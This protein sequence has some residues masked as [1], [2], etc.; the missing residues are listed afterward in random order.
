M[1]KKV[2]LASL[3]LLVSACSGSSGNSATSTKPQK[4]NVTSPKNIQSQ[5]NTN[6]QPK[7]EVKTQPQN[8]PKTQPK[9]E[10]KNQP[11]N[12]P[13]TQPKN[14]QSEI[15]WDALEKAKK[16][17]GVSDNNYGLRTPTTEQKDGK[18][19]QSSIYNQP[20]SLVIVTKTQT[21]S[22]HF[23][24]SVEVKGLKTE[25]LPSE[26]KATYVGEAFD[27]FGKNPQLSGKLS[28]D[29]DFAKQEGSGKV[30][31]D[32]GRSIDLEQG[33]IT[34][35]QISSTAKIENSETGTYNFS[36][37]GP[38]AEEIAGKIEM[39]PTSQEKGYSLGVA[40]TRYDIE[41]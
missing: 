34:Q 29:V 12:N 4:E 6:T 37:F 22:T 28:Y 7:N 39:K 23:S 15:D 2:A 5:S 38:N 3:V 31:R 13:K 21:D 30:E 11:Q 14:D 8:N 41:K 40:G 18:N 36:F 26:G 27:S 33:K 9:N 25:K 1:F 32:N 24:D 17:K 19:T 10:V 35:N 16:E 20:Y